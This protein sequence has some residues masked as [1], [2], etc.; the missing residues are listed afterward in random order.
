MENLPHSL[1]LVFFLV[2]Q[3][4]CL[5]LLYGFG[6]LFSVGTQSLLEVLLTT[7]LKHIGK[8]AEQT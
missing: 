3:A 2:M 7:V 4:L 6:D 8:T 1:S 5:L